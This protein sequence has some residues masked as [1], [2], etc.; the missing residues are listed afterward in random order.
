MNDDRLNDLRD[1]LRALL[2][3][4]DRVGSLPGYPDVAETLAAVRGGILFA[5]RQADTHGLRAG[6]AD[7]HAGRV[8]TWQP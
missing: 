1:G 4:C 7:T 6:I 3:E 8:E 5:M 2:A